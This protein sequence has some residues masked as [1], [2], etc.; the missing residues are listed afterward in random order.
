MTQEK[1]Q[2][3]KAAGRRLYEAEKDKRSLTGVGV[4]GTEETPTIHML[5]EKKDDAIGLPEQFEGYD[6]V[7][8][9]SGV[10]RAL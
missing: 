4:G 5:V 9:V 7:V 6:V 10:I 2:A 1:I 3:C 8:R